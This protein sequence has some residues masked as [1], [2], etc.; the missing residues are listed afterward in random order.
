VRNVYEVENENFFYEVPAGLNF[1][2]KSL[3]KNLS[4]RGRK[5]EITR[6]HHL[7]IK[8]SILKILYKKEKKPSLPRRVNRKSRK[9]IG[10]CKINGDKPS[11]N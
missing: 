3:I 9:S 5:R 2:G 4:L 6:V 8:L 1:F 11:G 10:D 7:K